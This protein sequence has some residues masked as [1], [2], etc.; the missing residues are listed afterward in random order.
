MASVTSLS[1]SILYL[2]DDWNDRTSLVQI[3][4][5]IWL[6]RA[7]KCV[8]LLTLMMAPCIKCPSEL[9]PWLSMLITSALE[10]AHLNRMRPSFI[11]SAINPTCLPWKGSL[12]VSAKVHSVSNMNTSDVRVTFISFYFIWFLCWE[13]HCNN[14]AVAISNSIQLICAW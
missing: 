4:K 6:V 9:C 8:W 5:I 14:F 11:I 12:W 10:Q 7:E 2:T 3:F 1:F 13:T